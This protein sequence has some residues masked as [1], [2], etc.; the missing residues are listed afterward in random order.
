MSVATVLGVSVRVPSDG[1]Q[2]RNGTAGVDESIRVEGKAWTHVARL[3]TTSANQLLLIFLM[4]LSSA[5]VNG[6]SRPQ[7]VLNGGEMGPRESS[8][9]SLLV[10]WGLIIYGQE[11]TG[12]WDILLRTIQSHIAHTLFPITPPFLSTH[13]REIHL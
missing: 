13:L 3:P 8:S 11:V 5:G 7:R 4:R 10:L 1:R 9:C 6:Q 12:S 2:I